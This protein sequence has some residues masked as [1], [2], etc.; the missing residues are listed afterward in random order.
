MSCLVTSDRR[1]GIYPRAW[2]KPQTMLLL[3][4]RAAFSDLNVTSGHHCLDTQFQKEIKVF[5]SELPLC[6]L[7]GPRGVVGGDTAV[8]LKHR[9]CQVAVDD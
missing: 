8:N 4:C 3:P 2:S 5:F 1:A 6:A 7:V 9:M